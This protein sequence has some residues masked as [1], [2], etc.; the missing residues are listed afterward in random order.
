MSAT[1][2]SNSSGD[3]T[4]MV[5]TAQTALPFETLNSSSSAPPVPSPEVVAP[6]IV[7]RVI[8][9]AAIVNSAPAILAMT[10]GG[11]TSAFVR[12]GGGSSSALAMSGGGST[13]LSAHAMTG[14]GSTSARVMSGG[15]ST[16]AR[17]MSGGSSSALAMSGGGSSSNDVILPGCLSKPSTLDPAHFVCDARVEE[18]S[19][20]LGSDFAASVH[21]DKNPQN[22]FVRVYK[23]KPQ[24]PEVPRPILRAIGPSDFS[25]Q[26]DARSDALY[27]LHR[28]MHPESE[29]HEGLYILNQEF[30]GKCRFFSKVLKEIP[31]NIQI[32][33]GIKDELLAV[34][35]VG[36]KTL[37]GTKQ[38]DVKKLQHFG[39]EYTANRAEAI[40]LKTRF[41]VY[42]SKAKEFTEN[43]SALLAYQTILTEL[44]VKFEL[45]ACTAFLKAW[46]PSEEQKKMDLSIA[47]VNA[48]EYAEHD[49]E[50]ALCRNVWDER[51]ALVASTSARIDAISQELERRVED[52]IIG[53]MID[54]TAFTK[55]LRDHITVNNRLLRNVKDMLNA[56]AAS[57]EALAGTRTG[58]TTSGTKKAKEE[59]L[60]KP[61][62]K[63][64]R[65]ELESLSAGG[66]G[67]GG[68]SSPK[69]TPVPKLRGS[70]ASAVVEVATLLEDDDDDGV[71]VHATKST[72]PSIPLSSI[73]ATALKKASKAKP[74]ENISG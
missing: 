29:S 10:G 2:E 55:S 37:L 65:A 64:E 20:T 34:F 68:G 39:D 14:G 30:E 47:L 38:S 16:S 40:E 21:E 32:A 18:S 23:E 50:R 59:K 49:E 48:W 41:S 74:E 28:L 70:A 42:E 54:L 72:A 8:P 36:F 12:T 60:F 1:N 25:L 43:G 57:P 69:V 45:P 71:V 46:R 58:S 73:V 27:N 44:D 22:G 56:P 13:S 6:K 4:P 61:T 3:S 24:A 26:R 35:N 31:K 67:G 15:G 33:A 17:V 11:S 53:W 9:A 7:R 63:A 5:T 19:R 51:M 66:G 62:T 52:K